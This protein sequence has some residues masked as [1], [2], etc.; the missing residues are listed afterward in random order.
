MEQHR[1]RQKKKGGKKKNTYSY[2]YSE[3]MK[4]GD[5]LIT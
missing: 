3:Y 5:L 2:P 1:K 4:G